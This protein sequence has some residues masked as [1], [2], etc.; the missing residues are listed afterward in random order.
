MCKSC[1]TSA[2]YHRHMLAAYELLT[3][4]LPSGRLQPGTWLRAIDFGCAQKV[5]EGVS[6]TRKTG[7]PMFMV[8]I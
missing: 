5:E 7:T 4:Y 1:G 2:E 6:L 8:R 3:C